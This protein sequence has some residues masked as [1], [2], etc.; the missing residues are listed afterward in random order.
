MN[1]RKEGKTTTTKKRMEACRS[2]LAPKRKAPSPQAKA[3]GGGGCFRDGAGGATGA[4]G[5]EGE[6]SGL[7]GRRASSR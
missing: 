5:E 4:E 7:R 3:E 6:D 2:L 1:G